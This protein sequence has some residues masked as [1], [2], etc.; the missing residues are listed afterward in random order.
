MVASSFSLAD[1]AKV[2]GISVDP[3]TPTRVAFRQR[4]EG[5]QLFAHHQQVTPGQQIPQGFS[6]YPTDGGHPHRRDQPA[7]R[8]G[9]RFDAVVEGDRAEDPGRT[10]CLHPQRQ[11]LAVGEVHQ[12][13]DR[14]ERL[15]H[16]EIGQRRIGPSR[17]AS[18]EI[19]QPVV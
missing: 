13:E 5:A 2:R 1:M 10:T 18:P 3:P 4:G 19:V 8:P 11:R 9:D 7:A 17:T 16:R 6:Q 12:L 15:P 14:H